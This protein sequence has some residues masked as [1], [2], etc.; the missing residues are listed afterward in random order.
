MGE[1]DFQ[2]ASQQHWGDSAPSWA[3]AAEE[4]ETG[5]SADAA[6]WMLDVADLRPGERVLELACG[7]GRVGLQ[8]ANIVAPDGVVLCSDFSA[9]MVEAVDERIA[10]AGIA[11]AET[12]VL[13]AQQLEPGDAEGFD[14][15]LCRF[16]YMLMADP[17]KALTE[18]VRVLRPGGRLVLAVWGSA[19]K[20]PWLS[21]ILTAVMAHFDAPPPEPGAPGPFALGNAGD[22][23]ELIERAGLVK[24]GVTEIQAEQTYESLEA[25]WER[26]R[27]VGGP[28][29]A[30]LAA[31]SDA[32]QAAIRAAAISGAQDFTAPDGSA[33]FPAAVIG[34][35]AEK[36]A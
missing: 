28:L 4:E 6:A 1:S 20:N 25:W 9:A 18:S 21:T 34:A 27:E 13:D 22:L 7:A 23:Q 19:E 31:L 32:D 15:V 8:A 35:K 3:R 16:G 5:A 24:V 30:V 17:L 11:N 12:R 14:V 26:L 33:V 29:A 2:E 36:A 10:R